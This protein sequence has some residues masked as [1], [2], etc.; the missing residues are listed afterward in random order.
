MKLMLN[1][2]DRGDN[3]EVIS[4]NNNELAFIGIKDGVIEVFSWVVFETVA[5]ALNEGKR[6]FIPKL[7]TKQID[8]SDLIIE[9]PGDE[10]EKEK[11]KAIIRARDVVFTSRINKASL[12]D[13]YE[14]TILNNWFIE[15]GFVITDD[16]REEKYLEIINYASTLSTP[17]NPDT[18]DVDETDTSAGDKVVEKLERYLL[19]YDRLQETT[20]L[21]ENF[22]T[23][24]SNVLDAEDVPTV[25]IL[26]QNFMANFK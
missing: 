10:L 19:L 2:L 17:D 25:E 1:V 14:F 11:Q 16:N 20:V 6:V 8:V 26:Y 13:F 9:A 23:F 12:I 7:L 22:K 18:P 5:R 15:K 24:E 4:I 21:Y 3:Y